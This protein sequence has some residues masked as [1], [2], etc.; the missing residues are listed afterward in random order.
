MSLIVEKRLGFTLIEILAV[1][2]IIAILSGLVLAATGGMMEKSK[3]DTA[4]AEMDIIEQALE[5]YK[6]RFGDYPKDDRSY[7]GTP[8]NAGEFLFNALMG[9]ISPADGAINV[10]PMLNHGPLNLATSNFPNPTADNTSSVTNHVV[11][12]W[13]NAYKYLYDPEHDS[14]ENYSYLLYSMGPDGEATDP[15]TGIKNPGDDDNADNVYAR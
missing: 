12:P 3:R 6:E 13:G 2:V 10:K 15:S 7:S 11:D 8:A 4:R 5:N 1:L 14:W 9:K